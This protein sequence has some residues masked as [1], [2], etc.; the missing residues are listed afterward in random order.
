MLLFYQCCQRL[1]RT[2]TTT[3]RAVLA[4]L[5]LLAC[6]GVLRPANAQGTAD[7]VTPNARLE[8]ID[9]KA[10]MH[11]IKAEVA[12]DSPT[13]TRGLMMREKLGPNEGMIFVF[14]DK[15]GHCFWMRNTLVALSIAFLDDDGTVTNIEDMKPQTEDSHCPVRAVRYALE[16]E[17]GWFARRGVKAGARLVQPQLFGAAARN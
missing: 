5:L 7:R 17:Q 1:E 4:T 12:A 13:R 2:S 15:A 14:P 9:I 10:G 11:L 16:M 3:L 8:Q 6:S